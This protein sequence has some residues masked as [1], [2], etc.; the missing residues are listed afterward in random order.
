MQSDKKLSTFT[1]ALFKTL[2]R[3]TVLA[4]NYNYQRLA[5]NSTCS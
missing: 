1:T 2:H 4:D 5:W 3:L